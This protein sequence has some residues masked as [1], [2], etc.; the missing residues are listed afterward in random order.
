MAPSSESGAEV[1]TDRAPEQ[2]GHDTAFAPG[3]FVPGGTGLA[4]IM[5]NRATARA[6]R[7]LRDTL[8]PGA[9]A[10]APANVMLARAA[11]SRTGRR[12]LQRDVGSDDYKAGYDDG[13]GGQGARP[14]PRDG[15]A[16]IDYEEAARSSPPPC[17]GTPHTTPH[18]HHWQYEGIQAQTPC[19]RLR[20]I[21][22]Q[23]PVAPPRLQDGNSDQRWRV[24]DYQ[25]VRLEEQVAPKS[26]ND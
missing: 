17:P 15:D 2:A 4:S 19:T 8:P 5:G 22:N 10:V 16:L 26:I 12:A 11:V 13:L 23:T 21:G 6:M 9:R 20:D 1:E 3:S 18:S 14:A 7:G 24:S 25:I